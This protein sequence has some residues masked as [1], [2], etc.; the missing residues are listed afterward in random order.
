MAAEDFQHMAA[1]LRLARR[2]LYTSQ[3]NPRVG[4][5]LTQGEQIVGTGFHAYAGQAHAEARALQAAGARARGGTCYVSLEPCAHQGRTPPCAAALRQAGI[6]RLVYAAADPSA[7]ASGGAAQL[8]AAGIELRSGVLA[9]AARALNPGFYKRHERG[10]PYVRCKLATSADGRIT[11][12]E[13]WIT[14]EPARLDVH[15]WRARS[16][17]LLTSSATVLAD[18]P[19][20]NVR[21][22]HQPWQAPIKVIVD[23]NLRVD[24]GARIWRSGGDCWWCFDQ[25]QSA[26]ARRLA[27]DLPN[28]VRLLP[29]PVGIDGLDLLTLARQLAR[30]GIN[31]VWC[32]AGGKLAGG[33]LK[34]DLVDQWFVYQAQHLTGSAGAA[35]LHSEVLLRQPL[36]L[37][38][39]RAVGSDWRYIYASTG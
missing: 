22:L 33:L 11:G 25:D 24:A 15:H 1:A 21:G 29:T 27:R 13:R 28:S 4:C 7:Q 35:M 12:T 34:A 38:D 5:V 32:E 23:S 20:L 39:Q 26:R 36:I 8:A 2:G 6:A 17:A 14:G 30:D 37:L 9:Q 31:E 10:L 3:P 16:D 19:E 18:D